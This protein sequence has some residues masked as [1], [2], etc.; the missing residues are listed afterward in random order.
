MNWQYFL[1][2][3]HIRWDDLALHSNMTNKNV[4]VETLTAGKLT[5]CTTRDTLC[6]QMVQN[7]SY[8]Q[9]LLKRYWNRDEQSMFWGHVD[10]FMH[11]TEICKELQQNRQNQHCDH[12]A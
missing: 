5:S 2:T 7:L 8:P 9:P 10:I 12:S 6:E 11:L 4:N 1:G 3:H